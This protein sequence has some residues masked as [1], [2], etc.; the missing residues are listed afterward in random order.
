MSYYG[1]SC[2]NALN[3]TWELQGNATASNLVVF[4]VPLS[5]DIYIARE[6]KNVTVGQIIGSMTYAGA[7]VIADAKFDSVQASII[8]GWTPHLI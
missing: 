8:H 3:H 6:N 2:P 4:G 7:Q 5:A 1:T